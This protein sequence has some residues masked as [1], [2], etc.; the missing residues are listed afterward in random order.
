MKKT[1]SPEELHKEVIENP[2]PFN[3]VPLVGRIN[4]TSSRKHTDWWR[5]GDTPE[6]T[7]EHKYQCFKELE[8]KGKL[9]IP[10]GHKG[11]VP[12]G[13]CPDYKEFM[14]E[15]KEHKQGLPYEERIQEEREKR[16]KEEMQVLSDTEQSEGVV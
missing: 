4:L 14:Q 12:Y 13:I 3:G 15:Y 11:G 7:E 6:A 2:K 9:K 5:Y 1:Y 8:E 16:R 10:E